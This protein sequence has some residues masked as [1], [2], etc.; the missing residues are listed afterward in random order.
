MKITSFILAALLVCGVS[1]RV[2]STYSSQAAP[3]IQKRAR[4][5]QH[6]S[7]G[8][9]SELIE[10]LEHLRKIKFMWNTVEGA[11]GYDACINCKI[12]QGQR[13]E[14]DTNGTV[15]PAQDMCADSPCYIHTEL[16]IGVAQAYSVRATFTDGT[17]TPWSDPVR[18]TPDEPGMT[19]AH[20][21]L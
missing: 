15:E 5:K 6:L 1:A 12:S 2:G 21:E 9:N 16:E 19:A 8:T 11:V 4:V 13:E 18:F 17:T 20:Q 10:G 14:N 7:R 3:V